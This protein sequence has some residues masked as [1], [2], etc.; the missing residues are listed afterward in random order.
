MTTIGVDI[1]SGISHDIFLNRHR[2]DGYSFC[3]EPTCA[4]V[5]TRDGRDAISVKP[6]ACSLVHARL[7]AVSYNDKK[8]L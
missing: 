8:Y 4:R 7:F 3:P 6:F 5:E 1:S 2:Y